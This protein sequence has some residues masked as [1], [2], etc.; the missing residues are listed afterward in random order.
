MKFSLIHNI[1]IFLFLCI[2]NVAYAESIN[3]INIVGNNRIESDYIEYLISSKKNSNYNTDIINLD[4][5]KL[6]ATD[7]FE[8]VESN[9][10]NG[11]LTIIVVESP[12]IEK[13]EFFGNDEIKA[14][15]LEKEMLS[16]KKAY[17]SENKINLDIQR[18]IDLYSKSGYLS[19]TAK[20]EVVKL[21]KN[22]VSIK[23]NIIEGKKTT[24]KTLKFIGN[25]QFAT[26]D[27]ESAILTKE[28]KW[29]RFLSA[30]DVYDKNRILYDGEM[31]R[32]FYFENGYPN[33]NVININSEFSLDSNQFI[34][35]Y[36]LSEGDR[37]K[38]GDVNISINIPELQE[39]KEDLLNIITLPQD[40]WYKN[41][42]LQKE[43]NKV[44]QK[45]N[46]L[47]YQFISVTTQNVYNDALH[48]VDVIFIISEE[49]RL[50]INKIE[51]T[52]N[53]KSKDYVIRRELKFAEQDAYDNDKINQAQ[54]NLYRTR[55][56][57]ALDL[58]QTQSDIP[59]KVNLNVN[60][61]E[62]STGSISVGG[63]YSTVDKLQFETSYSEANLF[64]TGNYFSANVSLSQ[65]TNTYSI[66]LADP[67]FLD[68]E[69][70]GS[71]SLYRTDS[72]AQDFSESD[73]YTTQE[74]GIG[75]S[76]G[77]YLTDNVRQTVGY[78]F[79]YR[80]I[81]NVDPEAS[82]SIQ[83]ISGI[84]YISMLTHNISYD[85]TDNAMYPTKGFTT[86][87]ATDYAGVFGDVYYI[88]NTAKIIHYTSLYDDIV[89]S[90]LFSA[91]AIVGLKGQEV[92][93][94]DKYTLGGPT[95]RGFRMNTNYGGVGP[96]D[97]VTQ[98]S[99]GGDYMFRASFQIDFPI[100]GVK[101]Y[102]LIAYVFNDYGTVTNFKD[103]PGVIDTGHIRG[104]LGFGVSWRSPAGIISLD[105][106][107]PIMKDPTDQTEILFL[108]FGTRF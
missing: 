104:S 70:S 80:N 75:F 52:G 42:L 24:I 87:L 66:T 97:E 106:G 64:G 1:L 35:T 85:T 27:L 89:F 44:K 99:L 54:R 38:F 82:Q 53:T 48:K 74:Q 8:R 50:F 83:Q 94:V 76:A 31:L 28:H 40:D 96:I 29:W 3:K 84:T 36:I 46:E 88:R 60:V 13:V 57:E 32:Q 56:F 98:E 33:F 23:I 41:S 17:Y 20:Y 108:N 12:L 105:F 47:G 65:N 7:Y 14:E 59:G 68:K 101:N 11:I 55:Y 26:A 78:R 79:Y 25:K 10:K 6:Y 102:G 21:D 100:P 107:W 15:T 71:V 19:A 61:T 90:S 43:I 34:I 45:I 16:K 67:Y 103:I 63:G 72:G 5:K 86:N 91:G 9:F 37:Y 49:Q 58:T 77:Y 4:L 69:V 95:L 39:Y 92:N 2:S 81:A 51:I 30:T 22:R 18:I 73:L 62:T 93:I